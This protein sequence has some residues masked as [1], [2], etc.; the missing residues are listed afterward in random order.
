[1]N[2][3]LRSL[4]E[5]HGVQ[6][7]QNGLAVAI[8]VSQLNLRDDAWFLANVGDAIWNEAPLQFH[9]TGKERIHWDEF[10]RSIRPA[11]YVASGDKVAMRGDWE[12]Q[13]Q[14]LLGSK[15][16]VGSAKSPTIPD[17]TPTVVA[18]MI[19]DDFDFEITATGTKTSPP[20]KASDSS[21]N[22]FEINDL[23]PL[24]DSD[25]SI[26]RKANA[27]S[28]PAKEKTRP[29][30]IGIDLGTTYSV[31]AYLDEHGRPTSIVNSVGDLLTPSVVLFDPAGPVIG[32]EA[33]LASAAE[34]HRVAETVKRDMGKKEYRKAINGEKL[35]PEVVASLILRQ[36]K[37]D[38]ER[39]LGPVNKVVITVPAYFDEPRRQSTIT[40]G[41]LAGLDVL[42]IINEPTAAA[43]AFGYQ[44]GLITLETDESLAKPLRVL[45][46][47]LGGGTFD[48]TIVQ[49]ES[50]SFKVI[51]TDGDV[52]L[53]G[54]DWDDKLINMLAEKYMAQHRSD[55]RET[56][57]GKQELSILAETAKKS[58][59][60]RP[61]ASVYVNHMGKRAKIEITREE[62][63]RATEAL[64]GRT[65]TTTEI[66]VLQA[67]LTWNDIDMVI[68]V[69]G[70]TRMPMVMNM[71]RQLTGK[72]PDRSINPDEAVAHGA[73]LYADLVLRRKSQ[74][75]GFTDFAVTDVNS[76]SL[77]IIG[78]DTVNRR[79]VNSILIPKNTPLPHSVSRTFK[80]YKDSQKS[81]RIQVLEGES[82]IPE[83][84]TLVGECVIRDLP[85]NLPAGWP[86][87]VA[88]AYS[89][90][91]RLRVRAELVGHGARVNSDFQR[92]KS[93]PD[94]DLLLWCQV[95]QATEEVSMP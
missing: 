41:K 30:C 20:A 5:R 45:V 52:T 70:S 73:A 57:E 50:N 33:V 10:V 63:E 51:A 4:I 23:A 88:F 29:P 65:R 32:K 49:I 59:T 43:I 42:E 54:K 47:D 39:R 18:G 92:D 81:I 60:E 34:P 95:V 85:P 31:I 80:T 48:V 69:G 93:L 53:G 44:R 89:E 79:R 21:A 9:V 84:C 94:N 27:P 16:S 74:E 68:L 19:P 2:K 24:S 15:Q 61:K 82:E 77:G 12:N 25:S 64:V 3:E 71:L 62:F 58:L 38:A 36:L 87:S 56:A 72:E 37:Q 28:D 6:F 46:F 78:I 86:I 83:A 26:E 40:A 76:H 14:L 8:G 35:P 55:P 22:M 67:G 17:S 90:D 1:M 13:I 66:V 7:L 91:S 75:G 11:V